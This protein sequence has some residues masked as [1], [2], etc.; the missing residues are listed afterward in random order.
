ME[1]APF[2]R[3]MRKSAQSVSNECKQ[4]I[5]DL[6][7]YFGKE[8]S[9]V[10]E[11]W[12]DNSYFSRRANNAMVEFFPL[13]DSIPSDIEYYLNFGFENVSSFACFLGEEYEALY[14]EADLSAF[15][16]K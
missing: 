9:W 10:L 8:N 4:N 11:Y 2:T 6:I 14:G 7:N 15:E 12:Y 3:D 1:Y 5:R 13:N 16:C